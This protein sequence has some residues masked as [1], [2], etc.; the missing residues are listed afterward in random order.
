MIFVAK[1]TSNYTIDKGLNMGG[2]IFCWPMYILYSINIW[3]FSCRIFIFILLSTV[4]IVL[5]QSRESANIPNK[6]SKK[7]KIQMC[8]Y[9]FVPLAQY[10][11]IIS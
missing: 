1:S 7:K 2:W 6:S 5:L 9:I 4:C 3:Q 10:I 11:C 8:L